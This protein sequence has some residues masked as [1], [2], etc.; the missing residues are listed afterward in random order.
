M[1]VS[2]M[3]WMDEV[4]DSTGPAGVSWQGP[5]PNKAKVF[6]SYK[7]GD[8]LG[9]GGFA[10]VRLATCRSTGKNCAMKVMTLPN[11][12]ESGGHN[13]RENIFYEIGLL[14]RLQ[15][16]YI[17]RLDEFFVEN[18][19]V[20]LAT[21]LLAGGDL[22]DA[23][24]ESGSYDESMARRIF[25]RVV[26]GVQYLHSEGIT[27]R[28]IKLENLLLGDKFDLSTVK[29]CDLGL[30][31]K[32]T[33]RLVHSACGTPQYVS[34]EVVN[35]KKGDAHGPS[36]DTWACGVVLF[37]LLC[38]YPPF[39]HKTET[40]LY[41]LICAGDYSFTQ[42]SVWEVITDDAKD[43]IRSF[44][45]VNQST[46]ITADDA[47]R[48]PWFQNSSLESETCMSL[49]LT[50][51]ALKKYRGK[52]KSAVNAIRTINRVN[53]LVGISGGASVRRS[54]YL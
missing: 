17:I 18:N 50:Q 30:A 44:L 20:Y 7:F 48:H 5:R 16:E 9:T 40:T 51:S 42:S 39:A 10:V 3:K 41:A 27:H 37:I 6:E 4:L 43:L 28:D 26:L 25:R 53:R 19:K 36:V 49:G 46:R 1:P 23:V 14:A 32:A 15:S 38:G 47:L 22:L 54:V 52:F 33:D 12:K 11:P 35:S 29:I 21:E 31:K 34:P 45:T 2:D 8:T 13:E 24:I